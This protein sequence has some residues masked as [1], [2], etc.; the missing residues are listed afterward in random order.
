MR[1]SYVRFA[2]LATLSSLSGTFGRA[3]PSDQLPGSYAATD[4]TQGQ[5]KDLSSENA[6]NW[7]NG[8]KRH[9]DSIPVV[10]IG[11]AERA[12]DL[13]DDNSH[14]EIV[15]RNTAHWSTYVHKG[16]KLMDELDKAKK[17]KTNKNEWRKFND[18]TK[19]TKKEDTHKTLPS[20]VGA[21]MNKDGISHSESGH[22][23]FWEAK[24]AHHG[25]T[26]QGFFD[27][28]EKPKAMVETFLSKGHGA[29]LEISEVGFQLA[30]WALDDGEDA[31]KHLQYI[32]KPGIK[33]P[34][35]KSIMDQA[36][37]KSTKKDEEVFKH[38]T[39]EFNALVGTPNGA[40]AARMLTDHAGL[41]G[42]TIDEIHLYHSKGMM[43]FKL[44]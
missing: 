10:D 1:S 12:N 24:S 40:V 22:Y 34:T 23:K 27:S 25:A 41:L 33:N 32:Y 14:T 44:K 11:I 20:E 15:P 13:D 31:L 29:D 30:G 37:A 6:A 42:K 43:V 8:I 18:K 39:D 5:A 7:A 19:W 36:Y 21:A 38:G 2:I 9:E 4:L 26:Y 35:S 17:H 3:I 28:S 16:K